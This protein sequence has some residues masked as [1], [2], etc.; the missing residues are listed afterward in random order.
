MDAKR[1][2]LTTFTREMLV[3]RPDGGIGRFTYIAKNYGPEAL[4]ETVSTHFGAKVD[5][6]IIFSMD[7]VQT[8]IDA[9]GGVYITV[10]DAEADYLNRYRIARDATTPSTDKAG[11]YLFGGHAAVIC[12]HPQSGRRRRFGPHAAHPHGTEHTGGQICPASLDDALQL[13]TT[14]SENIVTTNTEHG[15]PAGG[16]GLCHG[17]TRRGAG[18]HPDAA[19]GGH[20]ADHLRRHGHATGGL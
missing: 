14:V 2:M 18:G 15:R 13:L 3:K 11:T 17:A 12:M 8:I 20:G 10:T 4:C 1:V 16:G 5:K 9:M 19:G 7:N 6:Y